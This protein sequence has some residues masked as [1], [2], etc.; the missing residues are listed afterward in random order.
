MTAVTVNS[1]T[2]ALGA[3]PDAGQPRLLARLWEG[4]VQARMRQAQREIALHQYLLPQQL[5]IV[6]AALDSRSEKDLPFVR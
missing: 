4:F 2:I 1:A 5:E 6:G 3:K